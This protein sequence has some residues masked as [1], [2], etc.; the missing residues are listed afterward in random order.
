MPKFG[1][2][3]VLLLSLGMGAQCDGEVEIPTQQ[4]MTFS[5]PE[6]IP[7]ENEQ[8]SEPAP[9]PPPPPPPSGPILGRWVG[10]QPPHP[11]GSRNHPSRVWF[12][13]GQ[14]QFGFFI[15]SLNYDIEMRCF[16]CSPGGNCSCGLKE[17]FNLGCL[18]IPVHL[19]QTSKCFV[20]PFDITIYFFSEAK[21]QVS[22]REAVGQCQD[23]ASWHPGD[24]V[25]FIAN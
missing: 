7:P 4:P 10:S 15:E 9:L 14:D 17:F 1:L 23:G 20:D 18:G 19:N 5:P 25:P 8:P 24:M 21:A 11:C 12:T 16:T 22:F 3:L 13:V 2:I 6:T